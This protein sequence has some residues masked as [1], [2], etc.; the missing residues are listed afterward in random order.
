MR[1]FSFVIFYAFL[2]IFIG[3]ECRIKNNIDDWDEDGKKEKY[4]GVKSVSLARVQKR[5]KNS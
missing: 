5:V 1:H 3:F 2:G 4:L